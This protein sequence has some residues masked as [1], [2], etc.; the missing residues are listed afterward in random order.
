MARDGDSESGQLDITTTEGVVRGVDQGATLAWYGIPYAQPPMGELRFRRPAAAA[1]RDE[2]FLATS[3]GAPPVQP[4]MPQPFGGIGDA[5]D[6][7]EDCLTINVVRPAGAIGPLPVMVWIYGG[8]FTIGASRNY[9]ARRLVEH[10]DVVFVSMNYRVGAFGFL[11]LSSL[12]SDEA[13]FDTNVGLYDQILA[14]SWVRDNIAA[15]GGD[16][17]NVTIFGESAGA[18][19]VMAL[20]SMLDAA[21]LFHKAI[22]QSPAPAQANRTSEL[23]HWASDFAATLGAAP[24]DEAAVLK[25]ASADE[26]LAAMVAF[27]QRVAQEDAGAMPFGPCVDDVS[28]FGSPMA[29]I[30]DGQQAKVPLLIGTND[31]EGL[32]FMF[33]AQMSGSETLAVLPETVERVLVGDAARKELLDAYPGYPDGPVA[34]RVGGDRLFWYPSTVAAGAHSSVASTWVYLFEY[35]SDDRRFGALGPTHGQ[36]IPH[37]MGWSGAPATG[38]QPAGTARDAEFAG[39]MMTAWT[40]FAH[41]GSPADDSA[42]PRYDAAHRPTMILDE[43][44]RVVDDPHR[45]RRL[46]WERYYS[47]RD[48]GDE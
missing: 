20:M 48:A 28:L 43:I 15:F 39:A 19:S 21:G 41:D 46:A 40:R 23:A 1:P 12:S 22:A 37:M 7:S 11:D 8:A 10:G 9:D 27:S 30:V 2:T 25:A 4:P 45:D 26:I 38:R 32:L 16:P 36:E 5:G 47:V 6:W 29:T 31:N 44:F 24:G 33:G 3:W 34:A 17:D 42:W 13:V 14:L 35:T 18:M